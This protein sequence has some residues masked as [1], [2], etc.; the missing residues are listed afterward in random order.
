MAQ[1]RHYGECPV[2]HTE[3]NILI[4][5]ELGMNLDYWNQ[6]RDSITLGS[7]Y[8]PSTFI[9]YMSTKYGYNITIL[10]EK[11][12][13]E[14]ILKI[15]KN[16]FDNQ[17]LLAIAKNVDESNCNTVTEH[18]NAAISVY[19]YKP[20]PKKTRSELAKETPVANFD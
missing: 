13:I 15:C 1:I 8:V 3:L 10:R 14:H 7:P 16:I 19:K 12:C 18:Y 11:N 4:P 20:K 9:Q 2:L 5:K 17:A 6:I